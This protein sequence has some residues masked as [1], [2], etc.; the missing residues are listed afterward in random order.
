MS[1]RILDV[2]V[3]FASSESST[4]C[5]HS[6]WAPM[7][8]ELEL[9][10]EVGDGLGL[11]V[12]SPDADGIGTTLK[13]PLNITGLRAGARLQ[14]GTVSPMPYLLP[15]GGMLETTVTVQGRDGVNLSTPFRL[16]TTPPKNPLTY[17]VLS[18]A[19]ALAG[20]ELP[21]PSG[22]GAESATGYRGGRLELCA[23]GSIDDLPD[24]WFGYQGV[25]LAILTT[26]AGKEEFLKSLFAGEG[27]MRRKREAL[28]EWVRR[29]G[30]L[31][32]SAGTNTPLL[33]TLPGFQELTSRTIAAI[34]PTR[35]VDPLILYWNRDGNPFSGKLA[36]VPIVAANLAPRPGANG[37]ILIPAPAS[38]AEDLTPIAVQGAFGLGKVTV[39]GFDLDQP[40]FVNFAQKADFWDWVVREG[41]V[42]R[43]SAGSEGQLKNNASPAE[44]EDDL[45][46]ALGT[47]I[48]TFESV[49]VISFGWVAVLIGFYIVIV[50][51]VEYY[52]L[53][54][55]L[56][57][58][59]FTWLTFP[60][61]VGS[62]SAI[63]YL[64]TDSLKGRE[65]KINKI[66]VLDVDCAGNRLY[67]SS[68]STLFSPRHRYLYRPG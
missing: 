18:L 10:R 52:F 56:G 30:K 38:P 6:A 32:V 54:R 35:Q 53:R 39:I 68:W 40:A 7:H 11:V 60:I 67:G 63:A 20:F 37:R 59:E 33:A 8:V 62:A 16:T 43:A 50:G 14:T 29:G 45:A 31:V 3:G 26:G 12:E 19:S 36:A 42:N 17:V 4:I 25:D 5:K 13:V 41:G 2:R 44:D 65:L 57:R 23:V 24:Q 28:L 64:A 61:I 21:R 1:V 34:N 48:D 55:V 58:L 15:S 27:P 66:D 22:A 9:M 47:H 51:P 46:I 49:P